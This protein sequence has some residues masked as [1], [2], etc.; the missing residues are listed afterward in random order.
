MNA[1]RF[2]VVF[3][4]LLAVLMVFSCD[5]DDDRT[6]EILQ[7]YDWEQM[8]QLPWDTSYTAHKF[9]HTLRFNADATYFAE[10]NWSYWT[11]LI[12]TEYGIFDYDDEGERI[13]FPQ[14]FDTVTSDNLFIRV[15]LSPWQILQLDDTLLVVRSEPGYHPPYDP[16]GTVRFEGDTLY[17]RPKD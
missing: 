17:F 5:K 7:Q 14:A 16:G 2:R 15:Y 8:A 3:P 11:T 10:T 12:Y 9:F 4:F 13:E 1:S 6:K